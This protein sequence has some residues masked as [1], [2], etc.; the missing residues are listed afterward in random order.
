VDDVID[1]GG[2]GHCC[3]PMLAQALAL[4]VLNFSIRASNI[5]NTASTP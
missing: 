4:A 1:P 2:H 3:R 5:E